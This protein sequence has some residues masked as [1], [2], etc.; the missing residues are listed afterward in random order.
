VRGG[1]PPLPGIDILGAEPT[2]SGGMGSARTDPFEEFV[3]RHGLR[4]KTDDIVAYPRDVLGS[5]SD[6]DRHV[7][8]TLAKSIGD[9]PP[10]LSLFVVGATDSRTASARDVMW[11]LSADSWASEQAG[12]DL[13]RWSAIYGYQE[14]DP[15]TLRLMRLHARQAADLARLMGREPYAELLGIYEAELAKA[16]RVESA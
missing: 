14:D 10:V 6:L 1:W 5:P 15:S 9:V 8:V 7:L 11:W 13:Q 3:Q 12:G 4:I 2:G 16:G